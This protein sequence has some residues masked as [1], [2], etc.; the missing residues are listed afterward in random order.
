LLAGALMDAPYVLHRLTP[1]DIVTEDSAAQQFVELHGD[2][3]RYCHSRGKWLRWNGFYWEID[4]TSLAFHWVREL[5]RQLA[6]D[7]DDRKRYKISAPAPPELS[8]YSSAARELGLSYDVFD[9]ST[10]NDIDQVFQKMKDQHFQAVVVFTANL[11]FT[12]RKR[13]S[14][15]GL[16]HR[17]AVVA[18]AKLFVDDG[19]LLSYGPDFPT[20]W[21]RAAYFIDKI[22]KGESVGDIPVE[23]PTKFDFCL[24]LSTAKVL[25]IEISP[26]MLALAD[27]VIE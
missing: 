14:A 18:P 7:Q 8:Q 19:A 10:G 15:L 23:R 22:L 4:N 16:K 3:L 2:M 5:D 13:I 25:R 24:N 1:N 17:L 6:E 21:H 9:V 11:L 12:E 26:A 27:E 20:L